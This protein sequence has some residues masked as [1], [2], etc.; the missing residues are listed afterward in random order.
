MELK[1]MPRNFTPG[2]ISLR[3]MI[4]REV[5]QATDQWQHEANW[6]L[7]M[8]EVQKSGYVFENKKVCTKC[9]KIAQEKAFSAKVL[10][11]AISAGVLKPAFSGRVLKPAFNARVFKP[12]VTAKVLKSAFSAKVIKPSFSAELLQC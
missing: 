7:V 10:K 3:I 6:P 8:H 5:H 2:L 4:Q 9:W 11:S 1:Q 12:A